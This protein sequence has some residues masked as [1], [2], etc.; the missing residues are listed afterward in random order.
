MYKRQVERDVA[1]QFEHREGVAI[2]LDCA[3]RM[4]V[5]TGASYTCTGVT[6]KDES[7][8]LK[9]TGAGVS[10]TYKLKR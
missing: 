7:V 9:I 10:A 2:D 5:R 4:K 3:G 8:T 6:A 1:A